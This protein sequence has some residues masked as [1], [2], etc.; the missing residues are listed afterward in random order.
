MRLQPHSKLAID[1]NHNYFR[2]IPTFDTRLV[3]TGLLDKFLFQGLSGGIRLELPY[4]FLIYTN[5]GQSKR[6]QDLKASWNQMYGLTWVR[7]P[8]AGIRADFRYSRFESSF[9]RGAYK[10]LSLIRELGE[11]FRLEVQGGQQQFH[12]ALTAQNRALFLNVS[13]DWFLGRHYFLG[14]GT[15]FYRGDLQDYDQLFF[16][17]GYRF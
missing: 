10:S 7:I 13:G 8:R 1:L 4:R 16:N 15:V 6:E 2:W 14:G 9:G 3:G 17:L 12:S 11:S 5:V